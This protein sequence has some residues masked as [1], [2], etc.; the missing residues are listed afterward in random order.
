[1]EE[2]RRNL[3]G[4]MMK[5]KEKTENELTEIK[6][7]QH[8][9]Q[10]EIPG[11]QLSIEGIKQELLTNLIINEQ[12]YQ[13]LKGLKEEDVSIKDY[14]SIRVYEY[15]SKYMN[16]TEK[17]RR[18]LENKKQEFII[19]SDELEVAKNELK[20]LKKKYENTELDNVKRMNDYK[21]RDKH[22]E[23]ELTKM[24]LQITK[25]KEKIIKYEKLEEQ[26]ENLIKEQ[27]NLQILL[28]QRQN[29]SRHQQNEIEELSKEL[30]NLKQEISLL[31]NDKTYLQ[32]ETNT[33]I[34]KNKKLER[35][36]DELIKELKELRI[37]EHSDKILQARDKAVEKCETEYIERLKEL[38]VNHKKELESVR[39]TMSDIYE[40]RIKH[41]TGIKE[42]SEEKILTLEQQ[43]K[44]KE[45]EYEELVFNQRSLRKSLEE[46]CANLKL[47]LRFKSDESDKLRTNYEELLHNYKEGQMELQ[48][49]R[50][51]LEL[52]R[53]EYYKLE[54]LL[55]QTQVDARTENTILKKQLHETQQLEQE[56]DQIMIQAAKGEDPELSKELANTI[57]HGPANAKRRINQFLIISNQL[58][59]KQKETN[60]ATK[61]LQEIEEEHK[62][63][64][65]ETRR[66][67]R[68][69]ERVNQPI[70]YLTIELERAEQEL[71]SYREE[72]KAKDQAME[73]MNKEVEELRQVRVFN[74]KQ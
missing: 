10:R 68:I 61:K 58:L 69:S 64:A 31:A 25:L 2:Q 22:L 39:N 44:D 66:M 56:L 65:E 36:N 45:G 30:I 9:I 4:E 23:E 21:S 41:L 57:A 47:E 32:K 59:A 60:A 37:S 70:S 73:N 26:H 40:Q 6:R 51:K 3:K 46:E 63:Q 20:C 34:E 29:K 12:T 13:I 53:T 52:L 28:E 49:S 8:R 62:R 1:M 7:L 72:K 42:E 19:L 24:N 18:E 27:K 71:S 15:I 50:E 43:L 67:K 54:S 16:D 74:N 55:K 14:V 17:A 33:L 5:K 35:T 11:T 48:G 38:K